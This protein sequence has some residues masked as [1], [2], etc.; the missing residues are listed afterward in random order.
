MSN[1]LLERWSRLAGINVGNRSGSLLVEGGSTT[2][3]K[4]VETLAL[5]GI[6][7]KYKNK[8]HPVIKTYYQ[9]LEEDAI[10]LYEGDIADIHKNKKLFDVTTS[11]AGVNNGA[12]PALP[13]PPMVV[14]KGRFTSEEDFRDKDGQGP[15]NRGFKVDL[16]P[17]QSQAVDR[18]E[19]AADS[20]TK[21]DGSEKSEDELAADAAM[22]RYEDSTGDA[23]FGPSKSADAKRKGDNAALQNEKGGDDMRDAVIDAVHGACPPAP[24]GYELVNILQH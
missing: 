4:A 6:M 1:K 10:A 24:A 22:P 11:V 19:A 21:P 18:R 8:V 14:D 20:P 12:M 13:D 2:Y 23:G 16:N 15:G 17:F 9:T 3:A 7:K 5:L